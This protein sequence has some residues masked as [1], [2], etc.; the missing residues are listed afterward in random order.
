[1]SPSSVSTRHRTPTIEKEHAGIGQQLCADVDTLLFA[2]GYQ[3]NRRVLTLADAQLIDDVV[4][5]SQ[6]IGFRQVIGQSEKRRVGQLLL[7][8]Q[9]LEEDILLEHVG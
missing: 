8:R 1:M 5:L 2:T 4:H 7:H 6:F 3:E 9:T